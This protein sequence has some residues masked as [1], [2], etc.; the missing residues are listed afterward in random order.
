MGEALAHDG[1]LSAGYGTI[2]IDDCWEAQAPRSAGQPLSMNATRFPSGPK[3]LSAHLHGLGVNFGIYSDEG[4]ATCGG[5]PGSEGYEELDATTFADWGV[6][7]LKLDGCNIDPDASAYA[8]GYPKMGAALEASGRDIVFSCSWA[9][10]LGDNETAKPFDDFVDAGCNSW[11][12]WADIQCNWDSLKGI[13]DHWGNYSDVLQSA[14]GPGHWNDA[15]MLLVGNDC[16]TDLEAETQMAIWSIV[17]APLIMGNDLRTISLEM[18]D[19]LQNREV[20]AIDQDALGKAGRRVGVEPAPVDVWFRELDGGDVAVAVYFEKADLSYA[21]PL[22][23]VGWT[24][25]AVVRDVLAKSDLG[26]FT[27]TI[28][29]DAPGDHSVKLLRLTKA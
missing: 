19:L 5:Y 20:I 3:N 28:P 21:V 27:D 29:L 22:P 11:R 16:V 15:D 14:A 17:A 2:S 4:T 24:G 1:Y 18:K 26:S 8:T 6:D 10:Y 9:A 12:N 13:I 25:E 23:A 7:Y